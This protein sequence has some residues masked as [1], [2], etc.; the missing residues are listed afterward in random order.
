VAPIFDPLTD[1]NNHSASP[2]PTLPAFIVTLFHI[3]LGHAHV[4]IGYVTLI[5]WSVHRTRMMYGWGWGGGGWATP[6]TGLEA[7]RAPYS[8]SHARRLKRKE[9]EQLAGDFGTLQAALPSIAPTVA[10]AATTSASER[11]AGKIDVPAATVITTATATRRVA[12]AKH[13][14]DTFKSTIIPDAPGEGAATPQPT[15]RPGQIGEGKGTP[16]TRSQ[17]RRALYATLLLFS[18]VLDPQLK[19]RLFFFF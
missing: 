3:F 6:H 5:A 1:N 13:L 18:I 16:L 7:S 12:S 15:T 17:R 10:T 19:R 4:A 8:K 2:S 9:K 11:S 14:V